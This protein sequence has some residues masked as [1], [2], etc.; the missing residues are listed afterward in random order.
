MCF[1]QLIKT[2]N[3][4]TFLIFALWYFDFV[5]R[6]QFSVRVLDQSGHAMECPV[7]ICLDTT[8]CDAAN[9]GLTVSHFVGSYSN[10][11]SNQNS[12]STP[13]WVLPT[14]SSILSS[15]SAIQQASPSSSESLQSMMTS[16]AVASIQAD[17]FAKQQQQL[18]LLRP[19]STSS[20]T[21]FD[22][23]FP[24]WYP[25]E[26]KVD[27][28]ARQA[29][30]IRAEDFWC[31]PE[32]ESMHSWLTSSFNSGSVTTPLVLSNVALN[33]STTA[34]WQQPDAT[35]RFQAITSPCGLRGLCN[36]PSFF[37]LC[38]LSALDRSCA[39]ISDGDQ[40]AST[41][42]TNVTSDS[43]PSHSRAG[44]D[45]ALQWEVQIMPFHLFL[46]VAFFGV[47]FT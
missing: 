39:L 21:L 12:I 20:S 24:L 1:H 6:R 11:N 47:A 43:L 22:Q 16:L 4:F 46:G 36:C 27:T 40:V 7:P 26:I 34:I 29:P 10:S 25:Y 41:N 13:A 2:A 19:S 18:P 31:V 30:R 33:A 44:E 14:Q 17:L 35:T 42:S 5:L 37:S 9:L 32:F 15:N 28:S 23:S 8:A 45:I 38:C 3:L